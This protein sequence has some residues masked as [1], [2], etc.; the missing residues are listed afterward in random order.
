MSPERMAKMLERSFSHIS[1][2]CIVVRD[3]KN[4]L[5]K[6]GL[7]IYK[8]RSILT[9]N[10]LVSA[11]FATLFDPLYT[12]EDDLHLLLRKAV[13]LGKKEGI[14]QI[15]LKTFLSSELKNHSRFHVCCVYKAHQ[16]I[17]NKDPEILKK[18]FHRSCVRQKIK[19][20]L[21]SGL[22]I[23]SED[24]EDALKKFYNLYLVTRK[25][26]H[27]PPF[28]YQFL[29]NMQDVFQPTGNMSILLVEYEGKTIA[30]LILFKYKNRVSA[31]FAASDKNYSSLSPNH[32]A[33]WHAINTAYQQGYTLF[34]FGRT[35]PKIR[36]YCN[37]RNTGARRFAIFMNMNRKI[38]PSSIAIRK[39]N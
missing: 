7:P 34:D 39:K 37:L 12:E 24:S 19:R 13:E 14:A 8:V 21:C 3:A 17:L 9:G 33:F 35:S 11:P 38:I 15:Q 22:N 27:L 26:V 4:N 5:I 2:Q 36:D 10:R 1:G 23:L 20:S 6:A 28:P 25:R 30:G 29:K 32:Y 16:L 31:E 18:D